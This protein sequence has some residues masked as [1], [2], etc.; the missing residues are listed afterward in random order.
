MG[1]AVYEEP[2]NK[3]WAGYGV[4]A[5]CDFPGCSSRI[6]RGLDYKC[7]I[8]YTFEDVISNGEVIDQIEVETDGCGLFFCQNHLYKHDQ[9][10]DLLPKL[11]IKEWLE[12]ML[13]DE[14]WAEWRAENPERV[15]DMKDRVL[16]A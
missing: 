5:E 12:F 15:E 6:Q 9:H 14:S 3:R 2:D 1:Y 8:I 11:D 16:W 7:D 10:G 4:P 13:K